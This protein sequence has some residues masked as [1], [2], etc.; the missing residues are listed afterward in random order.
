MIRSMVKA[1]SIPEKENHNPL[2]QD[3]DFLFCNDGCLHHPIKQQRKTLCC[4]HLHF[5]V[6]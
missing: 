4:F 1:F 2:K 3:M 6:F 5:H